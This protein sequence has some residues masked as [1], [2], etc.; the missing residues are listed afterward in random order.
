MRQIGLLNKGHKSGYEIAP[1]HIPQRDIAGS[2][3]F[4]VAKTAAP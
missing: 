3:C 4:A 1:V 2:V